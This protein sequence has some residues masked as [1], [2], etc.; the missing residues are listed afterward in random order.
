MPLPPWLAVSP[1]AEEL[2]SLHQVA[3]ADGVL[4]SEERV[5][6]GA[7]VRR[8]GLAPPEEGLAAWLD[9]RPDPWPGVP[10]IEGAFERRF[11]ISEAIRVSYE[12]GDYTPDEERRIQAWARAWNIDPDEVALLEAEYLETRATRDPFKL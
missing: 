12:D 7:L 11:L 6:I 8:L 4:S 10:S 2:T 1:H 5:L 9:K 3:W